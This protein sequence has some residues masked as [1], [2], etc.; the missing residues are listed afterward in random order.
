MLLAA[1]CWLLPAATADCCR[2]QLAA[3]GLPSW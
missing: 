3:A 1:A 2:L